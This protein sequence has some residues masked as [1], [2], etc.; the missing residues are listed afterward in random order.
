MMPNRTIYIR[1]FLEVSRPSIANWPRVINNVTYV[2]R[3]NYANDIW[4]KRK[5]MLPVEQYYHYNTIKLLGGPDQPMYFINFSIDDRV[6]SL[7]QGY[8]QALLWN[9][10]TDDRRYTKARYLIHVAISFLFLSS[11]ILS[12][13]RYT[14]GVSMTFGYMHTIVLTGFH[15][16]DYTGGRQ[17]L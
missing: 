7:G 5:Q 17:I 15:E 4:R 1:Q 11:V 16:T 3:R 8:A 2:T 13:F 9:S 12:I 10:S 14:E 6:H